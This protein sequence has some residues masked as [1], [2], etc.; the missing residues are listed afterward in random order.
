MYS[1]AG[2]PNN[3]QASLFAGEM[4]VGDNITGIE[5]L[6]GAQTTSTM[7]VTT[8]SNT[9]MLYGTTNDNF[10]LVSFNTGAGALDYSIQN[11]AQTHLFDDKGV[12][13]LQTTLNFGNFDQAALTFNISKFIAQ[14][15]NRVSYSVLDRQRSQ[16]RVFFND[17]YGLYLTI[18]N[19]Q[20]VGSMPVFYPAPVY[21]AYEDKFSTG[22]EASFFASSDGFVYQMDKGSSFDGLPIDAYITLNFDSIKSPRTLKR[23][24]KCAVDITGGGYCDVKFGYKLGYDSSRI[25]QDMS[26]SYERNMQVPKWDGFVW[27]NFTWDGRLIEP[28]ECE[29]SGT[30]ENVALTFSSSTAYIQSYIINTAIIHYT[31]RRGIR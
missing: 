28:T 5:T 20:W 23:F 15:R 17:G 1:V 2:E 11:M 10:N 21:M 25:S 27:D 31:P 30:A 29:M 4:A 18:V 26:V 3:W 22:E 24:R 7:I 13:S 14:K 16:Y 19:G 8:R 6:P 9:Y 12:I